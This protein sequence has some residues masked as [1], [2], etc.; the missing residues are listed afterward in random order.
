VPHEWL[1]EVAFAL[2]WRAGGLE[3]LVLFGAVCAAALALVHRAVM[4][5]LGVALVPHLLFSLPMWLIVGRRIVMRPH[6]PALIL[7]FALWWCLLRARRDA[8]WLVPLPLLLAVWVNLHGSFPMGFGIVALDLLVFGRAHPLPWR[9]RLVALAACALAFLAQVHVQPTLLAGLADALGLLGIRSSWTRSA[10]AAPFTRRASRDSRSSLA[11]VARSPRG[12]ARHGARTALVAR[13]RIVA[14]LYLRHSASST[15]RARPCPS[16]RPAP[17]GAAPLRLTCA[18][19]SPPHFC[20]SRFR[21]G[22][23]GVPGRRA[24]ASST[25]PATRARAL[26]GGVFALQVRRVVA[27]SGATAPTWTRATASTG[28]ALPRAPEALSATLYRRSL[29]EVGAGWSCARRRSVTAA[30]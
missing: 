29:D 12:S 4:A 26:P 9:P 16:S 13:L 15:S 1:A 30:T 2:A 8:R 25:L 28:R 17:P 10:V 18:R 19:Q 23:A 7:P 24:L 6:L 27:R 20:V 3:G 14:L 5:R 11:A 21:Y 22:P